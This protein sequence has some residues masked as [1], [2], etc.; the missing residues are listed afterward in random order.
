MRSEEA[1]ASI[2]E[3]DMCIFLLSDSIFHDQRSIDLMKQAVSLKKP[4]VLVVMPG[5]RWGDK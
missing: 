4:C 3:A 1:G 5:A 2:E